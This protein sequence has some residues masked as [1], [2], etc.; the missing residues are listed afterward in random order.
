MGIFTAGSLFLASVLLYLSA[1]IAALAFARIPKLCILVSQ[2]INLVASVAGI[3][4][5]LLCLVTETGPVLIAAWQ[6]PVP[7][8]SIDLTMD[9]LSAYFLLALSI[10]V[11]CVSLYTTGYLQQYVGSRSVG[12]FSFLYAAFIPSMILVLVSSSMAMFFI[13]W[14]VMSLLSFF[15][16]I[17]ESESLENRKAGTLYIVMTHIGAAFLLIAFLI[18]YGYTG[19]LRLDVPP[20]ALPDWARNTV[21]VFFLAGF[22]IK[23]GVVPVHIWLPRAYPAAPA[24]AAAL[25]SGIMVKTAI[26]GMLRFI[27]VFLG[28]ENT[29]WG[30][31]IVVVGVVSAVVGVS[32]AFVETN[33]KRLI[34]YSS[35]ENVGIIL[36]GMGTGFIAAA[37]GNALVSALALTASLLHAFNHTL[38][39]GGLFLGAGSMQSATHTAGLEEMGGL[40]RRMPVTALLVLA[41]ALSIS[42]LVPFNGFVGE[43]LTYQSLFASLTDGQ[44]GTDILSILA[45]AALAMAGALAAATFIKMFGISF[46]GRPRSEHAEAAVE[47]PWPMSAGTGILMAL[48]LVIGLFPR[49]A[50]FLVDKVVAGMT[51]VSL[52]GKFEWGMTAAF[53]PLELAGGRISP[54]SLLAIVVGI[55]LLSL[56][57]IRIVGGKYI[58]RKYGTWDCGFEAMNARMQYSATGFSKPVGIVFRMLFRPSRTTR[59]VGGRKYHPEAIEYETVTEN[60]FE[61]YLYH[62]FYRKIRSYSRYTKFRIQTGRIHNYLLYILAAVIAMM[63]YNMV[64]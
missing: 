50:L 35:I 28:V 20:D 12:V 62:P 53:S 31:A 33:V 5:S 45:V 30:I 63:I 43:W 25:L 15:L 16:V 9:P 57:V 34:A 61:K 55:V 11:F 14:E 42:A 49:L 48:C 46:L 44:A 29:W 21:F 37:R 32:F 24:N 13:A 39:K 3:A 64:V 58:E 10:L 60:V 51:G 1:A 6:S 2:G 41:G 22:G 8:L 52:A 36:I 40:I 7:L 47:V 23:A 27:F 4:A 38:F 26:Y 56:V 59:M 54:L 18:I 19:S 17:F